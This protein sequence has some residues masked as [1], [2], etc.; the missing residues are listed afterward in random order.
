MHVPLMNG[1]RSFTDLRH[2]FSDEISI[3]S[4]SFAHGCRK[5]QAS[6]LKVS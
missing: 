6:A 4:A 3:F 5:N 1:D 2:I